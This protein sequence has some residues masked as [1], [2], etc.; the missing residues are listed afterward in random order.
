MPDPPL[1]SLGPPVTAAGSCSSLWENACLYEK[2][3]EDLLVCS[4]WA[5]YSV[6]LSSLRKLY[7]ELC[8]GIVDVAIS[9]VFPLAD[10]G[11]KASQPTSIFIKL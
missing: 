5:S 4:V 1:A 11:Q 8:Q 2:K 9:S 10:T 3:L 7:A 6:S